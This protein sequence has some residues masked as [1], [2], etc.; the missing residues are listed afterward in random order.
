MNRAR[1]RAAAAQSR[2]CLPYVDRV[3]RATDALPL[4]RGDVV[5][6]NIFH[7]ATCAIYGETRSCSCVPDV[8]VHLDGEVIVVDPEGRVS[9]V[10]LS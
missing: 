4:Q 6:G 1:R 3:R 8:S 9:K 10:R 5:F 7:D 2:R